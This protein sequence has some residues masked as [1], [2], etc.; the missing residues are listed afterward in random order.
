MVFSGK[1]HAAKSWP[2]L[3]N[4]LIE[5]GSLLTI[6]VKSEHTNSIQLLLATMQ[7]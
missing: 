7:V 6:R 5:N 4:M 3:E 1:F 2:K